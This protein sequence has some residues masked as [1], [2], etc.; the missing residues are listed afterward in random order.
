MVAWLAPP[1]SCWKPSF[2]DVMA[3]AHKRFQGSYKEI[4]VSFS[5]QDRLVRPWRGTT[6][7]HGSHVAA[8]CVRRR[9]SCSKY[10][11][12]ISLFATSN[13]RSDARLKQ[14]VSTV[15]RILALSHASAYDSLLGREREEKFNARNFFNA[16][17]DI[18]LLGH[19]L[20]WRDISS[21]TSTLESRINRKK[22]QE[23]L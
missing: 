14:V 5:W 19:R 22:Q 12:K 4:H 23:K 20:L 15:R 7:F 17:E 3:I 18:V 9:R 10:S 13:T 16:V 2:Q 8:R 6:V 21:T 1:S 11:G